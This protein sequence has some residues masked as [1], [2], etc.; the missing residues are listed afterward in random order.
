MPTLLL[1]RIE[2]YNDRRFR[3]AFYEKHI[4]ALKQLFYKSFKSDDKLPV[5][6]CCV[7]E[8]FKELIKNAIDAQATALSIFIQ[9]DSSKNTAVISAIDNGTGFTPEFLLNQATLN[10]HRKISGPHEGIVSAKSGRSQLGGCGIGLAQTSA[11]L[12]QHNGSLRISNL[13]GGA[14]I[15]F[16]STA[17]C[18]DP[19]IIQEEFNDMRSSLGATPCADSGSFNS[20][21]DNRAMASA[22]QTSGLLARRKG[23]FNGSVLSPSLSSSQPSPQAA[24]S[25]SQQPPPSPLLLSL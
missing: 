19:K 20:N 22:L 23:S 1:P 9:Y 5:A 15:Q 14:C 17:E 16:I 11:A 6:V 12:N 10:Y 7:L 3:H 13:G 18:I 2:E 25:S 24:S 21:N 4:K 8:S